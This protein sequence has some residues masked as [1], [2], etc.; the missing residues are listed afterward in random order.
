MTNDSINPTER[1]DSRTASENHP[2]RID[3]LP[4]LPFTSQDEK[5]DRGDEVWVVIELGRT[6]ED[7][8]VNR[9]FYDEDAA[10]HHSARI[11]SELNLL[12]IVHSTQLE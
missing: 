11:E 8:V 2:Y 6:N 7:P 9:V 3:G 1:K 4:P 10:R 12:T 5:E